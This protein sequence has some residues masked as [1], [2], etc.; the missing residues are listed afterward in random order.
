MSRGF[1][2]ISTYPTTIPLS[3]M[4]FCSPTSQTHVSSYPTSIQPLS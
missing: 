1:L 2:Y 3:V 4:D